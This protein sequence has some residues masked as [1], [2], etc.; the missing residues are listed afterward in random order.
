MRSGWVSASRARRQRTAR[1]MKGLEMRVVRRPSLEASA[2]ARG[3]GTA[4][5]GSCH[6]A[7]TEV[8]VACL[9]PSDGPSMAAILPRRAGSPSENR[10]GRRD[11]RGIAVPPRLHG[12]EGR[13]IY[14]QP[15]AKAERKQM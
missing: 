8:V 15:A 14:G 11:L 2:A 6:S 13:A 1:A 10:G 5:P 9:A 7:T 12:P 4:D 3:G